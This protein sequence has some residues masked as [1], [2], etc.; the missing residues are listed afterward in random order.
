MSEAVKAGAHGLEFDVHRTADGRI[1]LMHDDTLGRTTNAGEV[2]LGADR[3][4]AE[5]T[6]AELKRLDAAYWWVPGQ[7]DDHDA[8]EVAYT[9]RG[10]AATNPD[11]GVPTLDEVLG[12]FPGGLYTIEIKDKRAVQH[13]LE[14][15]KEH[16][17]ASE[18]VIVTSFR[19]RTVWNLRWRI[20]L[21]TTK[22]GVAPGGPST[23]W[24][25][26][27]SRRGSAPRR[28]PYVAIQV[29]PTFSFALLAPPWRWIGR[30]LPRSWRAFTMVD[31]RFIAYANAAGV[32]VHVWTINRQQ[33]M[34]HLL[35]AGV[36]GIMTDCP[37]ILA[38]VLAGRDGVG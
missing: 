25:F 26:L 13:T 38:G 16:E 22:F 3:L 31:D 12:R 8:P 6:L 28:S 27:R 14:L 18:Q 9:L 20:L 34:N 29:P 24:L 1:V 11:L 10:Q 4:I 2:G 19:E 32:A 35:D 23:M 17:V 33:E 30:L 37:T 7:V 36:H 15:L 5:T 21:S